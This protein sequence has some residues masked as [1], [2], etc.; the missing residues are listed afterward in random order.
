[1]GVIMAIYAIALPLVGLIIS[2]VALLFA[3][4][5]VFGYR[6]WGAIALFAVIVIGGSWLI[7]IELMGVPLKL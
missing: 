4:P 1:M 3:V 5:L 6:K 7:F 2:T